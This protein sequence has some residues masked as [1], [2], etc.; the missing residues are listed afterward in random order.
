MK[1][2]QRV[3][4]C[5]K[6]EKNTYFWERINLKSINKDYLCPRCDS[7][8]ISF[9][10]NL[11]KK[12]IIP[13]LIGTPF[14]AASA[15]YG[16]WTSFNGSIRPVDIFIMII[17]I[18]IAAVIVV[19]GMRFKQK[20]IIPQSSNKSVEEIREYKLQDLW[21]T[22]FVFVGFVAAF[23]T[24]IIIYYNWKGIELAVS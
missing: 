10:D 21:S 23:A 22:L 9:W 11:K 13:Y 8:I 7:N 18:L 12:Y 14:F 1:F 24:D 16:F 6:C 5:P 17:N 20:P 4:Y 3:H 15:V 19:N 2:V